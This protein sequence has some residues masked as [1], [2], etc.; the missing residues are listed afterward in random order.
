[1]IRSNRRQFLQWASAWPLLAGLPGPVLSFGQEPKAAVPSYS[2]ELPDMLVSYISN[3]ANAWAAKWDQVRS[4]IHTAADLE[5][6]NAFV[7]EKIREMLGGFPERNPLNAVVTRAQQRSGYRV[8][9]VM[10]QSRPNFWVTANL[11]VPTSGPGPFPGIISPCGHYAQARIYESYQ[12]LYQDLVKSGFVVLAYDPIGQGERRQ[13]WNPQTNRNELGGPVTWEHDMPGHLLF[14]LG[15]NLTE[16]RI[17]DGMRAIDYLESRPEVDAKRIGC[18]GHSGGG[19]LT[20][21]ISSVDERVQCAVMNEGGYGKRWPMKLGPGDEVGTGDVE[22]HF[23]PAGIYGIDATDTRLAVAPRPALATIEHYSPTYDE[24][25]RRVR[26]GYRLLGA[27]DAFDTEQALDP[28]SLTPKL[29]LRTVDWFCRW[30]Y[31]RPG[32]TVEPDPAAEAPEALYCTPNGSIRYSQQGETIFSL[33]LKKG[34]T[35]PPVRKAPETRAELD[36]FRSEMG[37]KIRELLRIHASDAPLGTRLLETTP[38]RGY[39]IEKV[40]FLSEPG[41]YIPAWVFV[42]EG[43]RAPAP[44]ILYVDEAGKDEPGM[45]FGPL[46]QLTRRGQTVIA[47]DVRGIGSTRPPHPDMDPASEFTNLENAQTAMAYWLWEINESLLGMRVQDVIRSVDYALSRPDV[48][49]AGVRLIGRGEGALWALFAA[50]LDA[51]IL[52]TVCERGLLSYHCLTQ[53]DRYHY[54][55]DVIIPDVLNHF[56]LPQVAAAV[57]ERSLALL[58]PVDG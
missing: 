48:G 32:P 27:P 50:A 9:N 46:E 56:D 39:H 28:H 58:A 42:P 47:I 29:R 7:R 24:Q 37:G 4:E 25:T 34:A 8:E 6:R 43:N 23:F 21:Y 55:A 33:I 40:E 2:A 57:A 16:Y 30:F 10:F 14:L 19:T 44:A 52:A 31:H 20:L 18:T 12:F 17:W 5:K 38:R 51:R 1:M 41:I 22:Q 36:S 45:E 3:K 35:L 15:E 54:D 53:A 13:F 26:E 49:G 11:Y